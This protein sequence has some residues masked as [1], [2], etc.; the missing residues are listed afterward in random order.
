MGLLLLFVSAPLILL[1]A[2]VI[3]LETRGNPFFSQRRVGLGGKQFTIFKLRGMYRDAAQRF[4]DLYDYSKYPDLSF[5]FHYENDPRVTRLGRF[6]R[7]TSIDELPNLVNVVL[8]QMS[9]VGPRPE[10]PDV[11]ALYGKYAAPYLS[12]KPGL[13][14]LSKISGR[15]RLTK[16]ES[17]HL[18][19]NYV[20]AMSF[21]LD[22]KI[23]WITFVRVVK[24]RDAPPIRLQPISFD[25]KE[26]ETA[27]VNESD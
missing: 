13:T 2:A 23:L 6:L 7:R 15:D 25:S 21:W 11:L 1:A 4:P 8:G 5:Y 12:V 22:I 18:D 16:E 20:N 24:R 27:T 17:I 19:L 3:R 10:I 26:C 14:C 9:L